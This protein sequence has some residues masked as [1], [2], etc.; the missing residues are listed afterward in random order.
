MMDPKDYFT[1]WRNFR[2]PD[3]FE[4]TEYNEDGVAKLRQRVR[5]SVI[6]NVV[7]VDFRKR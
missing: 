4:P 7:H 6:D 2:P 1:D 5:A 3:E